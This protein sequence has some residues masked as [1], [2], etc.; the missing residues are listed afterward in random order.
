MK[1]SVIIIGGGFSGCTMANLL[2][3]K[4][5]DVTVIEKGKLL[6]GGCRTFFHKGHPYTYGPRHLNVNKKHTDVWEYLNKYI[7]LRVLDHRVC[8]LP[9]NDD[10]FFSYPPHKKEIS[11]MKHSE[12]IEEELS[13]RDFDS[14][15]NNFEEYWEG[16]LGN[17]LY[18]GFIKNYS[19]KMWG[20]EDNTEIDLDN[21]PVH[22]NA[23][24][25]SDEDYFDGEQYTA[26]PISLTGYNEYFDDCV[27]GCTVK[28]DSTV[29][30]Y[31]IPNKKLKI[32]NEWFS[33][34]IIISTISLDE[35]FNYS[36][37]DLRY[38]GRDF[39]KILLPIERVSPDPYYFLYYAGDEPYTRIVE[40]KLLTGYKS[41][42]TLLVL[43]IPSNSNKLYPYPMEKDVEQAQLYKNDI[44]K[45]VYSIGRMGTYKYQ[46]MDSIV[47]DCLN[48]MKDL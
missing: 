14:V 2:K 11:S 26:Y 19:K 17:V 30:E 9:S 13:N 42:D 8:T 39:I 40:Y 10:T 7:N 45:D 24:R 12:K 4:D 16:S 41:K 1:K 33:P 32:D 3:Q 15:A 37:G 23:L 34:D 43:E 6:G 38:R 36:H 35:I 20:I 5:Y 18:E 44:P 48:I 29:E 28:L 47:Q 25:Q 22:K 21:I 31:D 46:C 27:K